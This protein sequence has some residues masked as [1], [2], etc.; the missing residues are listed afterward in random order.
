MMQ[1]ACIYCAGDISEPVTVY[2]PY[3]NFDCCIVILELQRIWYEQHCLT[4]WKIINIHINST[5][6]A[7]C[8]ITVIHSKSAYFNQKETLQPKVHPN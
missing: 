5:Y 2:D 7:L 3:L 8:I 1:I 4:L 6:A